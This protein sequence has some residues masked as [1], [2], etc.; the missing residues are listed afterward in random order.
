MTFQRYPE[1]PRLQGAR[2]KLQRAHDHL[3][4]INAEVTR[5]VGPNAYALVHEIE[6]K[7]R[8]HLWR[9]QGLRQLNP[10]LPLW[11]GDCVHNLRSAFD[12]IAFE[13]HPAP[14][15]GTMFPLLPKQPKKPVYVAPQPG[16]HVDAMGIVEEIQPYK[17]GG[18][19]NTLAI[20]DNLDII[21][22]HR[23]LLATVAAIEMP[24]YGHAAHVRTLDSWISVEPVIDGQVLMWAVIE[25]AQP[26]SALEG[27]VE[28]SV[29][30]VEGFP[31]SLVGVPAVDRYLKGIGQQ[32]SNW[33]LPQF[34]WFFATHP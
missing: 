26:Q 31:V 22:K 1:H 9:I 24:W 18:Y 7:G 25:P 8:K 12:H 13:I 21:D 16:P 20:L 33:I 17:T 11:I 27:H 23:E 6:D 28:L 5:V 14:D 3:V 15:T 10:M 32:L 29:K 34:D 30:L 4:T 2:L 19:H